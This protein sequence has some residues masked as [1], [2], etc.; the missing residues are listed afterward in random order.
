MGNVVRPVNSMIVGPLSHFSGCEVS[1]L[2]RS[3]TVWNTMT[4]DKAF[5]QS[6]DGGFSRGITCRKG[7]SITIISI[8][9]SKNTT[10]SFP[11]RKWS[12]VVN[13]LPG[14]WLVTSS[15]G[16]ISGVQCWFLL[17]ADLAFSSNCSQVSLGKWKSIL[18]S[19]S[20]TSISTTM[21]TLFMCPLSNDRD[22]WRERL[23]VHRTYHLIHLIIELLLG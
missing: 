9:S 5:C 20:I 6:V 8:Y 15:N 3:N 18:L 10:L 7:K 14:C 23:T 21:T 16:A 1:S 12:N 11:R 19:P 2:V 22:G 17:L 13:L 4:T